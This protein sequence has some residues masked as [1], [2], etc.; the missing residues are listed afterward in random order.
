MESA[1]SNWCH[2]SGFSLLVGSRQGDLRISQVL[3]ALLAP[4]CFSPAVPTPGG[5]LSFFFF[6]FSLPGE[7]LENIF[8]TQFGISSLVLTFHR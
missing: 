7:F 1:E 5:T 6:F 2:R 8:K 4:P 3:C